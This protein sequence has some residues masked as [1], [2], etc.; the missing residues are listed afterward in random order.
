MRPPTG[1]ELAA[2]AA[3]YRRLQTTGDAPSALPSRWR[4]A[5]R[6][7]DDD[8]AGAAFGG[9]APRRRPEAGRP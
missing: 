3:A 7:P 6:A 2:I 4:L 1:E 9:W 5:A 8:D